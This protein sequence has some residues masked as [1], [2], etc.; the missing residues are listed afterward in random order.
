MRQLIGNLDFVVQDNHDVILMGWLETGDT[1]DERIFLRGFQDFDVMPS[2]STWYF[3]QD[4]N[5][6][7]NVDDEIK[8]G[9]VFAFPDSVLRNNDLQFIVGDINAPLFKEKIEPTRVKAIESLA[10]NEAFFIRNIFESHSLYP[11]KFK[12]CIDFTIDHCFWCSEGMLVV[13]GGFDEELL[14]RGPTTFA[15]VS[16]D[17]HLEAKT[18]IHGNRQ[19]NKAAE[20]SLFDGMFILTFTLGG[21]KRIENYNYLQLQ[22]KK[23]TSLGMR[24]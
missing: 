17:E 16:G 11:H 15:I 21:N 22:I 1:I 12:N 8:R 4:V 18:V 23:G 5:T 2:K 7:L 9:F 24:P 14:N 10:E 20:D 6:N 3:R 19:N 13:I